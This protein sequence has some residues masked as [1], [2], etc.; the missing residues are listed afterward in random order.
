MLLNG[1]NP[2]PLQYAA[3]AAFLAA[4]YRDYLTQLEIPGWVCG[5]LGQIPSY[6]LSSV[7]KSQIDYMLGNNPRNRSYLIGIGM[8]NPI[9]IHHQGGSIPSNIKNY[10]CKDGMQWKESHKENPNKVI[11][12]LVDGPDRYDR[13][14]DD[15]IN[16]NYTEPT[17]AGNSGLV[18]A[19]VALTDTDSKDCQLDYNGWMHG[20]AQKPAPSVYTSP[21]MKW[22]PMMERP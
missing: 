10:T 7:S 13:F 21:P 9:H 15:R 3:N 19:L 20:Y 17:L 18:A 16:P 12:A 8:R 11:G 14:H 4:L 5:P 2:K 1:K 6:N 22:K